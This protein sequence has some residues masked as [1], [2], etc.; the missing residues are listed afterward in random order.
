MS[1]H[2]QKR[3]HPAPPTTPSAMTTPSTIM[4]LSGGRCFDLANPDPDMIDVQ[5]IATSLSRLCRFNGHGRI[6]YS[7]AEH[8][9][10][11]SMLVAKAIDDTGCIDRALSL[12]IQL[13][14]LLHD[15]PEAYL[16][17]TTRPMQGLMALKMDD[18]DEHYHQLHSQYDA[19]ILP[20][21]GVTLTTDPRQQKNVAQARNIVTH[22][23]RMM[24]KI[25]QQVQNGN[26]RS[27]HQPDDMPIEGHNPTK[28]AQI[29]LHYFASLTEQLRKARHA[30]Q[31]KGKHH[32]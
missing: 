15:A 30:S 2:Q 18:F 19:L 28:A 31:P 23:D 11:V 1:K 12:Q 24:L 13:M 4:T 20:K 29:F 3:T 6:Y 22:A 21:L 26:G 27:E 14:A 5:D 17:D 32:V 10:L 16:G 25:E 8:S 7:V 9:V